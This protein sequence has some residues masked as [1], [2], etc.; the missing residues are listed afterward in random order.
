MSKTFRNWILFPSKK[1][2]IH[3]RFNHLLN[4][5]L[6]RLILIP[7]C[8]LSSNLS[9]QKLFGNASMKLKYSNYPRLEIG[10]THKILSHNIQGIKSFHSNPHFHRSS[11]QIAVY[12]RK[13]LEKK[14]DID[15]FHSVCLS[16]SSFRCRA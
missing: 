16:I 9:I 2:K 7:C 15:T 4:H 5:F 3:R 6:R 12:W 11:R 13:F 10:N 8:G 1:T 14:N